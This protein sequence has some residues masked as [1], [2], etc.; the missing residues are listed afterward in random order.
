MRTGYATGVGQVR[1]L[2]TLG[3]WVDTATVFAELGTQVQPFDTVIEGVNGVPPFTT[4]VTV[5]VE[6]GNYPENITISKAL[7]L[8]AD[9][10]TVTI[11]S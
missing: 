8:Q 9:G 5:H 11:G 7:I 4:T 6:A 10:G 1:T 2:E 3:V